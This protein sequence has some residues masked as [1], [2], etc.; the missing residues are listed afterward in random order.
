MLG[1]TH[2]L[3]S[4]FFQLQLSEIQEASNARHQ[5]EL[6]QVREATAREMKHYYLQCLHQLVNNT[7]GL[8]NHLY[9][10]QSHTVVH[11]HSHVENVRPKIQEA[12]QSEGASNGTTEVLCTQVL[13]THDSNPRDQ[14]ST[15]RRTKKRAVSGDRRKSTTSSPRKNSTVTSTSS[16]PSRVQLS[17]AHHYKATVSS[18]QKAVPGRVCKNLQPTSGRHQGV[19]VGGGVRHSG[20]GHTWSN[21]AG[22]AV[23]KED[24]FGHSQGTVPGGLVHSDDSAVKKNLFG[25][26]RSAKRGAVSSDLV[27]SDSGGGS[28]RMSATVTGKKLKS[29]KR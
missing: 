28:V 29:S 24:L 1:F 13:R 7:N 9:R 5:R 4:L 22:S 27:H 12:Y 21:T 6:D 25:H 23:K 14:I 2:G 18:S 17:S 19:H 20:G 8:H 11:P 26:T 10:H 16:S 3:G 15:K